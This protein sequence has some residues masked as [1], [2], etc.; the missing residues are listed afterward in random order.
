MCMTTNEIIDKILASP[1]YRALDRRVVER[2]VAD[3]T[4]RYGPKRA[5]HET[6]R[7]LHQVWGVYFGELKPA[8]LRDADV[9]MLLQLHQSTRERLSFLRDFY[10]QIFAITGQPKSI[11]D[12]A[13]GLNPLAFC[14]LGYDYPEHY[15]AFDIDH[16]TVEL[17]NQQFQKLGVA[18][19]FNAK[20]GDLLL[21]TPIQAD[22]A[23]LLKV[24]P[25][26]ELQ[27]KGSSWTILRQQTSHFVVASYPLK[28]VSGREK[29]MLDFYRQQF[30]T[31]TEGCS[32]RAT[33]LIFDNELV[34][35][36][37]KSTADGF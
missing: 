11:V 23:L 25:P 18:N 9:D 7:L 24:L 13:C 31:I 8:K 14:Q 20:L 29:G 36:I 1:K 4:R 37:K 6:K 10:E 15:Q 2:L 28:S 27:H 26:L 19:R 33:E 32:W 12:Y 16:F 5:E 3:T 21:D 17:L 35:I 34:F 30:H 22:V